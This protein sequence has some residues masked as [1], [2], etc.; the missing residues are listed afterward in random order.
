[1]HSDLVA[2]MIENCPYLGNMAPKG[3]KPKQLFSN[4][5]VKLMG[6]LWCDGTI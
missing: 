2:F 6:I 1:M 3:G 5:S 4:Q